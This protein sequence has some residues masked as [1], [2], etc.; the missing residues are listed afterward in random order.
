[1]STSP[2]SPSRR[3]GLKAAGVIAGASALASMNVPLV[4]AAGSDEIKVALVGCGGRGTGAALNALE[5][6]SGPIKLVAM[7][8]VF[9][10]KLEASLKSIQSAKPGQV[11]VPE[12]RR[13]ISF[14]GYKQAMDQLKPGDVVIQLGTNHNWANRG[15]I[16]CV[17]AYVLIA[18]EGAK[19]TGWDENKNKAH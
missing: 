18:T 4:H 11:E 13:F 9:Q 16:P 17:M 2:A 7:A 5:T 12:G 19:T 8:D 6:K 14:D 3:D 10:D 15:T 1:M